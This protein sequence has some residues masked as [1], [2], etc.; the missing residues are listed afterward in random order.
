MNKILGFMLISAFAI[1]S[2]A[3]VVI[4]TLP[5]LVPAFYLVISVITFIIYAFDKSAAINGRWRTKESTLHLCAILG[6]W[7]GALLA[8]QKLRHKSSKQD[9]RFVFWITVILNLSGF[10]WLHTSDGS[11]F[12]YRHVHNADAQFLS[13]ISDISLPDFVQIWLWKLDYYW[14]K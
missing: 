9:F 10:I 4:H 12:L 1:F 5:F 13:L 8:Q 2:I 6:G 11:S 14:N 7:P 3:S